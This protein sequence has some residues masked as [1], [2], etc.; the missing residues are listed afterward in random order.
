MLRLPERKSCFLRKPFNIGYNRALK[1]VLALNQPTVSVEELDNFMIE[2]GKYYVG[3]GTLSN[4]LAQA[5]VN[6]Y[7]LGK[8]V[9]CTR[10]REALENLVNQTVMTE[11]NANAFVKARQA[12][13]GEE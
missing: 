10:M 13:G 12:L 9:E 3:Q 1:D 7:L 2:T 5:I 6:K 11:Y 8:S 4:Y